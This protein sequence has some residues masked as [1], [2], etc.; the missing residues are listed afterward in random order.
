MRSTSSGVATGKV[1]TIMLGALLAL[2]AATAA[3]ADDAKAPSTANSSA[4]A[5]PAAP[6]AQ[7]PAPSKSCVADKDFTALRGDFLVRSGRTS[8]A[9][10]STV[11]PADPSARLLFKQP[12]GADANARIFR[13]FEVEGNGV[14][15]QTGEELQ[16]LSVDPVGADD[17]PGFKATDSVSLR[18]DI[19]ALWPPWLIRTFVVVA[20]DGDR[21]SG[22]GSISAPVSHPDVTRAICALA[23]LLT[24]VLAVAAIVALRRTP[25]ALEK[26]YPAIFGA[27]PLN[28]LSLD[29][30][31]PIHLTANVFQQASVQKAQVLLFSLLVG[32]MLLSFVL[33]TGALITIS[34]TVVGLLGISGIGAVAAQAT[35]QQKTR[36]SFENW[37]W[38]EDRG[39]LKQPAPGANRGPYWRELVLTNREF[40]VYK[41]QTIIFTIVVAAA[42]IVDGASDLSTFTVPETL[43]GVLGLSQVVYVGGVLVKPPATGDLD[44]ALTKM[45]A[46]AETLARA[47][48]QNTDTDPDGN[49]L[50]ALPAGQTVA[51]NAQRQYDRF[52]NTV[53]HM[54]EST[55]EVEVDR[56]KLVA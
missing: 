30:W 31:N 35:Y 22:W 54:I 53:V 44:A 17:H 45:R 1:L 48:A 10:A 8:A 51:A 49:L 25:H 16:V 15:N 6:V 32:E 7:A 41:L 33:R 12:A 5:G 50:P 28:F 18:T 27:R 56:S 38:L 40:D 14:G 21:F 26:K 3:L 20:C 13:V 11:L 19:P 36:L 52:T 4:P 9:A 43:L 34:P 23:G 39:A 24:Y 29:A 47:K 42:L 2:G 37:A 55:L 46:M